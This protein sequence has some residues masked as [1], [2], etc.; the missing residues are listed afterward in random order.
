MVARRFTS[1]MVDSPDASPA[2]DAH[3]DALFKRYKSARTPIEV[4][5]RKLVE[6]LPYNADR[7]THQ[8]HS[9]PAKLIPHIPFFF[10]NNTVLSDR[11]S[12]VLDPFCGTGTTLLE[13]IVAGRN[14]I[15]ADSNPL[16]RLISHTKCT[17]M[18]Q[19]SL[20]RL[21]SLIK[22]LY[23]AAP[24]DAAPPDVVNLRYWFSPRIIV[25]L[26]RLYFGISRL[27]DSAEKDLAKVT[28]SQTVRQVSRADL[29]V[30]VP[31]RLN[32]AR[33]SKSHF[34]YAKAATRLAWL[35]RA[36]P[37][38]TFLK[39]LEVNIARIASLSGIPDL[40]NLQGIA[41]DA[42][43]LSINTG[44]IRLPSSSVDLIITSPP[45]LGAQKYI[46]ASSL[47]LGWLEYASAD[48]LTQ[49]EAASI[50]REHLPRSVCQ[51]LSKTNIPAAD[52]LLA[53]VFKRNPL[54][55]QIAATYLNEMR[56][57][58]EEMHRVLRRGGHLVLVAGRNQLCRNDFDTPGFL[59]AISHQT[60]F[61][62]HLALVDTIHS[63]GL[64]TKR[65]RTA[66]VIPTETVYV[67]R[68][69]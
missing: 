5:F 12:T 35:R 69:S 33:F 52:R 27:T 60:G 28:F 64:M 14:T 30:S 46:R 2:T 6:V 40:G 58:L 43:H 65:N 68:R 55:A 17:K 63:R 13:S 57:S 53:D 20:R 3:L 16:A 25:G 21:P 8:L 7:L 29:R 18:S 62:L 44:G 32:L 56:A 22:D 34:L 24:C 19:R 36:S 23:D 42:R 49:V 10:L 59:H 39:I 1:P 11:R 61:K 26:T 41:S 31:V 47:S 15:G 66:G 45:Y 51:S 9:Y 38:D 67:F 50:G 48:E 54:R 4:N 37:R